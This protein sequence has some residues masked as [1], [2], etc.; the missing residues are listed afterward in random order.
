MGFGTLVRC[1]CYYDATSNGSVTLYSGTPGGWPTRS[2][3]ACS[4]PTSFNACT[5]F[6]SPRAVSRI[7]GSEISRVL[8][9]FFLSDIPSGSSYFTTSNNRT[10]IYEICPDCPTL[11]VRALVG[12]RVEDHV[13]DLG[14][15]NEDGPRGEVHAP[16]HRQLAFRAVPSGYTWVK[17]CSSG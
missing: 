12:V 11:A 8:V 7:L 2:I 5:A 16:W 13:G 10:L 9:Q 3:A 1:W 17:K 6:G 14:T 4:L 15:R